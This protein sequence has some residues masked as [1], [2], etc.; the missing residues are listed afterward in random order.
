MLTKF[1]EGCGVNHPLDEF[2]TS[3]GK[4]RKNCKVWNNRREAAHKKAPAIRE[5][6]LNNLINKSWPV[7]DPEGRN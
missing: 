1:C 4:V 2:A 6:Y 7:Y 3:K 5:Q